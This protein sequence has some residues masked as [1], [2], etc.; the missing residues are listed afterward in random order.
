MKRKNILLLIGLLVCSNLL[1]GI[2]WKTPAYSLVARDMP[3]R[4]ALDTFGAAQGMSV[5][6]SA[7][8][9]GNL[10]GDFKD[11]APQDFLD[12]I[13]TTHNFIWY[14]D[15][16]ALYVYGAGE[17]TSSLMELQY[18]REDNVVRLLRELGLEDSRF[19]IRSASNGELILVSGPPRYVQLI[20]ETIARADNLKRQ[21]SVSE[22]ETRVF[23]LVNTWAD[24]VNLNVSGLES[25]LQISG[26]AQ[27]LDE[28]MKTSGEGNSRDVVTNGAAKAEYGLD[29]QMLAG[30]RPVIKPD[31]RLNAV[32]VRDSKQRMPM[33]ERLIRELD[34][35]QKI[36]EIEVTS[37]DIKKSDALDW[38][39]SV[40]VAGASSGNDAAGGMNAANLFTPAMLA[41]AGAA[42]AYSYLGDKVRV[43]ASLSAL[44]TKGKARNVSR[45]AIVTLNNFTAEMTD[46]QSYHAR[47]VGEKVAS[48][49]QVSAGTK[50]NV[51]PRI[52]EPPAGAT[53]LPRQVW[54]TMELEDG[55]FES[56]S[57]DA[58]PMTRQST[59]H[60]QAAIYEND[61][62]LLGGYFRDIKEDGGWGIP[63]LRDIP[64][65]GWIFGGA[66]YKD[67]TVQRLFILTPRVIDIADYQMTTQSL[68]RVQALGQRDLSAVENL[69]ELIKRDDAA[70][71]DREEAASEQ[72][73]IMEEG[74]EERLRRNRKEREFRREKRHERQEKENEAWDEQF[75]KRVEE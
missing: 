55:G 4:Q 3:L 36:V 40:K 56:V 45:T 21:R 2:S 63:Y 32:I 49:E 16:T 33:Y 20:A 69:H 11:I 54:L 44:K 7:Q 67:E 25:Q 24:N 30:I 13:S 65:I 18:M 5:V 73:E 8:V 1:A 26:V 70:R 34:V 28:I 71:T 53:N 6:M 68:I 75:K 22:I 10:S 72:N 58:M 14:Y 17:I 74:D 60:T 23:R 64:W 15:G 29:D 46:T 62:I 27:L 51:K 43:D 42:G 9:R 52:V 50:L 48:L 61:A 39:L 66:T 38:Q 41:G 35:P 37:F 59:L 12:R 47:V 57:V 19:P 31:N